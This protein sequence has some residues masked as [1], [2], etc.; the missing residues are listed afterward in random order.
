MVNKPK[1]YEEFF[2]KV[3]NKTM[4]IEDLNDYIEKDYR[5]INKYR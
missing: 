5:N 2:Y 3:D 1:V 4:D